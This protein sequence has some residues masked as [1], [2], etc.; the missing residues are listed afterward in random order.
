MYANASHAMT[1]GFAAE[2][3]EL[4]TANPGLRFIWS[5]SQDQYKVGPF[6]SLQLS[7]LVQKTKTCTSGKSHP[8]SLP[9][10]SKLCL[11]KQSDWGHPKAARAK[12]W[13]PLPLFAI[14]GLLQSFPLV[15]FVCVNLAWLGL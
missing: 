3:L 15:F 4:F 10:R 12:H 9:G 11:G 14:A 2:H 1:T 5:R 8:V 13:R 6:V 7:G